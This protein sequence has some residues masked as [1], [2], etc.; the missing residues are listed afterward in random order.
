MKVVTTTHNVVIVKIFAGSDNYASSV[1]PDSAKA[2]C[3]MCLKFRE[4]CPYCNGIRKIN[5]LIEV[6]ALY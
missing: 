6:I 3:E 4:L 1:C 2:K 5:K